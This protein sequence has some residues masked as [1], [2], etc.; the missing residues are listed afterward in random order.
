ML[1]T[2][3]SWDKR[4]FLENA[5]HT[6][7]VA[8]KLSRGKSILC[9]TPRGLNKL[10]GNACSRAIIESFLRFARS[11]INNI[12]RRVRGNPANSDFIMQMRA[13]A[14]AGIADIRDHFA[15]LDFVADFFA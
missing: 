10:R 7:W 2:L 13:S 3:Y 12:L 4:R 15:A 14:A 6:L 1:K 8:W 9:E 5:C 11:E